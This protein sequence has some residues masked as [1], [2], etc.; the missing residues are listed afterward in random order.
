MSGR[1]LYDK[2]GYLGMERA[3]RK[4]A[5]DD[6]MATVE[7]IATMST[8]EV[9]DLIAKEYVMVFAENEDIG[10]VHKDNMEEYN[11]ILKLISR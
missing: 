11:K 8:T 4:L 5:I 1:E 10:L 2:L 7:K 6:K 9:C 3:I